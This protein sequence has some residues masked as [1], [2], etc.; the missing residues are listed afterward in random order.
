MA[1]K[2]IR[3]GVGTAEIPKSTLWSFT[4]GNSEVYVA[5][6]FTHELAKFSLHSSGKWRFAANFQNWTKLEDR[7]LFKWDRPKSVVGSVVLGPTI[8]FPPLLVN[9]PLKLPD[10]YNK[11]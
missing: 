1:K 6:R 8:V 9:E 7:A 11:K 2:T 4:I 10:K 3:I 5:Q